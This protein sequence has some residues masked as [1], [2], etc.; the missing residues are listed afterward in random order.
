[1]RPVQTSGNFDRLFTFKAGGRSQQAALLNVDDACSTL[2]PLS[3][4][5]ITEFPAH[6]TRIGK[7]LFNLQLIFQKLGLLQMPEMY[8]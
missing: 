3:Q 5:W 6:N 1:M 2:F 8:L 4:C 7:S